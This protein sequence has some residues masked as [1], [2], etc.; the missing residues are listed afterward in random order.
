[1][2]L[3]FIDNGDEIGTVE[4]EQRRLRLVDV[5]TKPL[6]KAPLVFAL[7]TIIGIL[8]ATSLLAVY[9]DIKTDGYSYY[10]AQKELQFS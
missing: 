9:S 7:L 10:A 3:W 2:R 5:P 8:A 1:M 4:H 6:R